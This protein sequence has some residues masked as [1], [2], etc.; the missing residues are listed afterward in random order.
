[1]SEYYIQVRIFSVIL[2]QEQV[3]FWRKDDDV[4]FFLVL[5]VRLIFFL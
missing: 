5:H 4:R 3:S 2:W 1:M